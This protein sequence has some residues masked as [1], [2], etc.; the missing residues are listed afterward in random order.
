MLDLFLKS[1]GGG[2]SFL[3][4]DFAATSGSSEFFPA[5]PDGSADNVVLCDTISDFS[6]EVDG[7]R[8]A[9]ESSSATFSVAISETKYR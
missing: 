2:D 3:F 5:E 1:F 7:G 8:G 6:A 9:S 4:G